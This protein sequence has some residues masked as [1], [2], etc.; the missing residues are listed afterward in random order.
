MLNDDTTVTIPLTR[1]KVAIVDAADAERVLS[2][3]WS[4]TPSLNTWYAQS[5]GKGSD[6]PRTVYLHRFIMGLESGRIDH[7]NGDGLDCRRQNL[8]EATQS[9][10]LANTR[11]RPNRAGYRGVSSVPRGRWA[12]TIW[13][14][15]VRHNIG[16]FDTAEDAA[17][18]Y[19]HAARRLHGEFA[20]PNFP[21]EIT[22][23][24]PLPRPRVWVKRGEARVCP[25]CG[26][27]FYRF[28]S[29]ARKF[30]SRPCRR[31]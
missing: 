11:L 20:R 5:G 2:R 4:A 19:D 30:C 3:K 6:E 28:P 31:R 16:I 15:K 9:Q 24:P 26:A 25:T 12:A 1:G 14:D 17:R 29:Q 23:S 27:T 13:A 10:N 8:R 22:E 18:A 7:Q 21:D